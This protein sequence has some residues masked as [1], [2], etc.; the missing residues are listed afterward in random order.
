MEVKLKRILFLILIFLIM[1]M[2]TTSMAADEGDELIQEAEGITYYYGEG[3]G[4]GWNEISQEGDVVGKSNTAYFCKKLQKHIPYTTASAYSSYG[5][6]WGG[7]YV[8]SANDAVLELPGGA[9]DIIQRTY[10]GG[11]ACTGMGPLWETYGPDIEEEKFKKYEQITWN[12]AEKTSTSTYTMKKDEAYVMSHYTGSNKKLIQKAYWALENA[13]GVPKYG[14]ISGS[15]EAALSTEA[16]VFNEYIKAGTKTPTIDESKATVSYST[17]EELFRIGPFTADYTR[18]WVKTSSQFGNPIKYKN[19]K[20]QLAAMTDMQVTLDNGRVLKLSDKK[21]NI[22]IVQFI[23]PSGDGFSDYPYPYP[24]EEFYI[25]IPRSECEN[26]TRVSEIEYSVRYFSESMG[27]YKIVKGSFVIVKWEVYSR[28]FECE[29]ERCTDGYDNTY[30]V[31]KCRY[32]TECESYGELHEHGS[33]HRCEHGYTYHHD[34]P[35]EEHGLTRFHYKKVNYGLNAT[36]IST[37]QMQDVIAFGRGGQAKLYAKRKTAHANMGYDLGGVIT[38]KKEISNEEEMVNPN[39]L[40][41]FR[42]SISGRDDVTVS[43][44]AGSEYTVSVPW[45]TD[46]PVPTFRIEEIN[47]PEGYAFNN[48]TTSN[49][50]TSGA[51]VTG[52]F[53]N[54]ENINVVYTNKYVP[55]KEN[56]KLRIEKKLESLN[57]AEIT[58]EMKNHT[59]QFYIYQNLSSGGSKLLETVDVTLNTPFE[60]EYTYN[61]DAKPTFTIVEKTDNLPEGVLFTKFED[62]EDAYNTREKNVTLENNQTTTIVAINTVTKIPPPPPE[63]HS[64]YIRIYKQMQDV[65]EENFQ[66]LNDIKFKFNIYEKKKTGELKFI[67]SVEASVN[68]FADVEVKWQGDITSTFIVEEDLMNNTLFTLVGFNTE[69]QNCRTE[70]TVKENETTEV[71]ATNTIDEEYGYYGKIRISKVIE[72]DSTLYNSTKFNF[73]IYKK[74]QSGEIRFFKQVQASVDEPV[75]VEVYLG[76]DTSATFIV[77]EDLTN[78]PLFEFVEFNYETKENN[79]TEIIVTEN[80]T[81]NVVATNRQSPPPPPVEYYGYIKI[82]KE[83]EGDNGIDFSEY[84]NTPFTF[85]IYQKMANEDLRYVTQVESSVNGPAEILVRWNDSESAT[86]VVEEIQTDSRFEF[87]RFNTTT[88]NGRTEII[89]V[90]E[91]QT[92]ITAINKVEE[93]QYAQIKIIKEISGIYDLT[94]KQKNKE[95]RVHILNEDDTIYREVIISVNNP[96]EET[97]KWKKGEASPK[98]KV[99]EDINYLDTGYSFESSTE[100]N[101]IEFK[102]RDYKEVIITNNYI[103]TYEE[104]DWGKIVIKKQIQG[105]NIPSSAYDKEFEFNILREDGTL[106]KTVKVSVNKGYEEIFYWEKGSVAPKYKIEEVADSYSGKYSFVSAIAKDKNGNS[107]HTQGNYISLI[108]NETVTWNVTNQYNDTENEATLTISKKVSGEGSSNSDSFTFQIKIIRDSGTTVENVS[109]SANQPCTKSYTLQDGEKIRYEVKEL[110]SSSRYKLVSIENATGTLETGSNI[111]VVCINKIDTPLLLLTEIGGTVWEDEYSAGKPAILNGI[112]DADEKGIEKVKVYIWS[113]RG[114]NRSLATIYDS[115]LNKTSQPVYTDANGKWSANIT[116]PRQDEKYD[117][118]FVYDGQTYESTIFL[119]EYNQTTNRYEEGNANTYI[120]S[121]TEERPQYF[122]RSM[123][124]ESSQD[125]VNF[126]NSFAEIYGKTPINSVDGKTQGQA[127]G[128]NNN[129]YTLDYTSEDYAPIGTLEAGNTRK[130]STLVT[131]NTD[132]TVI[133]QYE[134]SARTSTGGILYGFDDFYHIE[135]ADKTIKTNKS[136]H[137]YIATYEYMRNINLGLARRKEA[138]IGLTKDLYKANVV[139]NEKQLIYN[140]NKA[141]SFINTSVKETLNN[142]IKIEEA[143]IKYNLSLYKTDYFYRASIYSQ[144]TY[145]VGINTPENMAEII[146]RVT[147]IKNPDTELEIFLTYKVNVYNES[148]EYYAQIKELIDYYDTNLELIDENTPE[149]ITKKMLKNKDGDEASTLTVVAVPTYGIAKKEN[150]EEEIKPITWNNQGTKTD[151]HGNQYNKSNTTSLSGTYLKPGEQIELYVTYRVKKTAQTNGVSNAVV[152]GDRSNIAEIGRYSTYYQNEDGTM[153]RVAGKI[154][155]DSAPDN[156]NIE[157]KNDRTWYEDDTDEAPTVTIGLYE[158]TRT[159]EGIVWEDLKNTNVKDENGENSAY[160]SNGNRRNGVIDSIGYEQKIG[161][162]IYDSSTESGINDVSVELVEKIVMDGIEYDFIWPESFTYTYID[163]N[164][165]QKT[166]NVD[167]LKLTGLSSKTTTGKFNVKEN[168]IDNK[169][170]YEKQMQTTYNLDA[171]T[172]KFIGIPAGN[173]VVRFRYG[174]TEETVNQGYNGQDYK[175]TIYQVG[176]NENIDSNGNIVNEWHNLLSSDV[177]GKDENGNVIKRISDARDIEARRMQVIAYSKTLVNGNATVLESADN[178][179]VVHDELIENT[180]MI[181]E[182]AKIDFE[183]EHV[184]NINQAEG[185]EYNEVNGLANLTSQGTE[186]KITLYEYSVRNVDF[187]IERRSKTAL[188]LTK[189]IKHISLVDSSGKTLLEANYEHNLETGEITNVSGVGLE[190]MQSLDSIKGDHPVKGFRYINIDENIMQG[191]TIQ[192]DYLLIVRNVGEVDRLDERL[193]N[194]RTDKEIKDAALD[195]NNEFVKAYENN[196][197]SRNSKKIGKYLG[198]VYY[199]GNVYENNKD[200]V[201]TTK[202]E[203][204]IDYVDCNLVFDTS[205]NSTENNSWTTITTKE[206]LN[207]EQPESAEI[208]KKRL[209]DPDI[210]YDGKIVDSSKEKILYETENRNNLAVNVSTSP[211]GDEE[212]VNPSLIKELVPKVARNNSYINPDGTNSEYI[213]SITLTTN[214]YISPNIDTGELSYDNFAEIIQFTSQVGRRDEDAVTGNVNPSGTNAPAGEDPIV[215]E[216]SKERDSDFTEIVTLTPP[217]GLSRLQMIELKVNNTAKIVLVVLVIT[218]VSTLGIIV[219]RNVRRNK[220]SKE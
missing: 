180:N 146:N 35:C 88:Q 188:E 215:W 4:Y 119:S 48:V 87:V 196:D 173:F 143:K 98:L 149:N 210:L 218:L 17:N 208:S 200:R 171:G 177:A 27:N 165:V 139:V 26:A 57:G 95:F 99:K 137:E 161:D 172:Y 153:G 118:E 42:L 168:V 38:I 45:G 104:K 197:L 156:I 39:Q 56:G 5:A 195:V 89:V 84:Q 134:L 151:N 129:S 214:A 193:A 109:V 201:A 2:C 147:A 155:R 169:L 51:V 55:V 62:N 71:I 217:T 101:V 61:K 93:Y 185:I 10:H 91:G 199:T 123:A 174:D 127:T 24:N 81:T 33:S 150:Q 190:H 167:V 54:N 29:I 32:G 110:N 60:K 203:K 15:E 113:V 202:V 116:A 49:G 37:R 120:N 108:K 36:V 75:E 126:D 97:L 86:F 130:K 187:G 128:K 166:E 170:S 76:E 186:S 102:A 158:E 189:Q 59:Y 206:L 66:G 138:D 160:D 141:L 142:Q 69:T 207:P 74:E 85:N 68:E 178:S 78:N 43:L 181:A 133:S 80:N 162:G 198:T 112:N 53:V 70:I 107:L 157:Q 92:E 96:Y 182:T 28:G 16:K 1:M 176:I 34:V 31:R 67:K 21:I 30:W 213:G 117:I 211:L 52:S 79:R 12:I 83:F 219:V 44:K 122:T 175:S 9:G 19:G 220:K 14:T 90:N 63:E 105:S 18:Y 46:D 3:N 124:K 163:E 154:D 7:N 184:D 148:T 209:I 82:Y 111:N 192:I 77:E 8:S 100:D 25:T 145:G 191:T 164:N 144:G 125:R 179:H 159:L 73:N 216:T 121:T 152:L 212:N 13:S 131:H 194:L 204:I 205:N 72:G 135:S 41:Q 115:K 11:S 23:R 20:L 22:E 65:E 103:D 40:F 58:D 94:E 47:I 183:I 6:W 106:Y 50:S 136:D 132:G 64:G 114:G 140:Y